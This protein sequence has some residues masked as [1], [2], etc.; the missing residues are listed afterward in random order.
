[1]SGSDDGSEVGCF[2]TSEVRLEVG[3]DGRKSGS[4]RRSMGRK[5]S[6]WRSGRTGGRWG[7][8]VGP[9]HYLMCMFMREG[10]EVGSATGY[11][12][13]KVFLLEVSEVES[14]A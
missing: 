2:G 6:G 7:R 3:S 5:K 1:M 4:G 8:V 12:L 14:M 10:R 9:E 11:F 13:V